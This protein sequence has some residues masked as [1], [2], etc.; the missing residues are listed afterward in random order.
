MILLIYANE[1]V[2]VRKYGGKV[3]RDNKFKIVSD[4]NLNGYLQWF[5]SFWKKFK[6]NWGNE[7]SEV[8]IDKWYKKNEI[9]R[10]NYVNQSSRNLKKR[11]IVSISTGN[12]WGA[13]LDI[14]T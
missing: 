12:I 14:C 9:W 4:Q 5:T 13:N 11:K 6:R 1:D 3:L 2:K 8:A 7:K 10:M